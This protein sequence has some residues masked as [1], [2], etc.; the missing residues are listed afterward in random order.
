[1]RR[2]RKEESRSNRNDSVETRANGR[3]ASWSEPTLP[4]KAREGWG[5]LCKAV[6]ED[7]VGPARG[8]PCVPGFQQYP[9]SPTRGSSGGTLILHSVLKD[10]T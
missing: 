2:V 5:N 7:K 6:I 4:Q 8:A 9:P 1:M 10:G 3:H